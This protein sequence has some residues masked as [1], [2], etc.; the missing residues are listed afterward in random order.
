[1]ESEAHGAGPQASAPRAGRRL[2]LH[3]RGPERLVELRHRLEPFHRR[4]GLRRLA[5]QL[6][7]DRLNVDD[8]PLRLPPARVRPAPQVERRLARR[9]AR[10]QPQPAL[11]QQVLPVRS[12]L[13]YL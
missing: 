7:V 2:R 9:L 10:L 13:D 5:T 3:P 11:P 1:M 8:E 12:E 4:P 6:A